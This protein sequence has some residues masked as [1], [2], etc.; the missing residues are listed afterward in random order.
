[1][2]MDDE[3]P[4][5]PITPETSTASPMP[6]GPG[7]A[8]AISA[9]IRSAWDGLEPTA[10]RLVGTAAAAIVLTLVGLPLSVW[11]SAPFALL[12]LVAGIVLVMTAWF[13]ASATARSLPVPLPTIESSAGLVVAI[14][15]IFK[16]LEIL[17]DLDNLPNSGG[18]IGLA[19]ALALAIAA[20][21]IVVTT[22]RRG[23]D[24]RGAIVHGDQGAKLAAIGLGLVLLG[25]AFNLTV[26]FWTMGQAALPLAI[27]AIAAV[28]IVE[29]PRIQSPIPVAWV[30]AAIGAF[31]AIL[32]LANWGD[33]IGLGRTELEL[34]AG[35]FLGLLACTA[36]TALIIAGGVLSGLAVW[37]PT[38]AST[39]G[40]AEPG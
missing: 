29:A 18:I 7:V 10:R 25:W 39:G 11:D 35:D 8:A 20:V 16:V 30:G 1:M 3:A 17:A 22:T 27:L 21:V 33:L 40:S 24:L 36:G 9:D 4:D 15:A 37:T 32:V 6:A 12:L 28:T 2:D 19:V 31:G 38:H 14:L 5:Q 23:T 26:S 34:N 13:S